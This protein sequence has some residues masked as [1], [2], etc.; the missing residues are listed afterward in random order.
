MYQIILKCKTI[1]ESRVKYKEYLGYN[2]YIIMLGRVRV[3][4]IILVHN[5]EYEQAN[6]FNNRQA[7]SF[8]HRSSFFIDSHSNRR[9]FELKSE[10]PWPWYR[11]IVGNKIRQ[12]SAH[13]VLILRM[14]KRWRARERERACVLAG[15]VLWLLI[16]PSH[17]VPFPPTRL[18]TAPDNTGSA[19]TEEANDK[20]SQRCAWR[21]MLEKNQR[22]RPM[23]WL[24]TSFSASPFPFCTFL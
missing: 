17:S 15:P 12:F 3:R 19:W 22:A 5:S 10:G 24:A 6:M 23:P 11:D 8:S 20:K 1:F 18:P 13:R 4:F 21:T 16:S 14:E 9:F 7:K 2:A